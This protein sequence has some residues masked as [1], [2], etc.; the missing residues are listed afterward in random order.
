MFQQEQIFKLEFD[1]FQSV[2]PHL[3]LR[4]VQDYPNWYSIL[5]LYC[6]N[7]YKYYLS[8]SSLFH[9]YEIQFL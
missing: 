7:S 3:S 1:T 6:I 4:L 5:S 8:L 9:N 2:K